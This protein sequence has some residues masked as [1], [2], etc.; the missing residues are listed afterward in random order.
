MLQSE[1]LLAQVFELLTL[2]TL[3]LQLTPQIGGGGKGGFGFGFGF[4]V[5]LLGAGGKVR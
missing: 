3:H 5:M 4:G 1:M 2:Q